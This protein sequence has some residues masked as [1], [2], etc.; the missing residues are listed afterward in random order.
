MKLFSLIFST[1]LMMPLT[2]STG[3]MPDFLKAAV[4]K[5]YDGNCHLV[6]FEG[7]RFTQ[8]IAKPGHERISM[9]IT[10][11]D[12]IIYR[13]FTRLSYDIKS[14]NIAFAMNGGMYDAR[15]QPI[16][17]YVEKGV[18]LHALNRKDGSGN[19]HMKPN[20]VFFGSGDQWQVM[21]TEDFATKVEFRPDFGTQSGPML[22][23]DGKLH[24]KI[25]PNGTSLYVR[26]AV[27]VDQTG[28]AHFVISENRVSFGRMARFMQDIAR[29]PNALYLDG[30]VSALWDPVKGR[31]DQRYPLGPLIVVNK[32]KKS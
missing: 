15:S 23:I 20:G 8:C 30:A 32:V 17:Y 6:R 2:A 31:L 16:G 13:G 28:R 22:V 5:V 25:A 24:P 12:G 21:T 1:L 11:R 29:T 19:F 14:S 3:Q 26:N 7:S 9:H 4:S 10:G 27:G 18:K